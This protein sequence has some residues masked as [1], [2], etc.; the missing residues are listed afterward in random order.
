M[1]E[2]ISHTVSNQIL[3]LKYG[4]GISYGIG[5]KYRPIWVSVSELEL[6]QISGFFGRALLTGWEH[7]YTAS[8]I[9]LLTMGVL[10]M[11]KI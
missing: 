3:S 11:A 4:L 8:V 5:R 7:A 9:V 6:N 1:I 10:L 2:S